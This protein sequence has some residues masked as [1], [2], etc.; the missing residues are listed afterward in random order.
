MQPESKYA[1]VVI[2]G[3]V[4]LALFFH[5]FVYAVPYGW[6]MAVWAILTTALLIGLRLGNK[7]A[8]NTWAYLFLGPVALALLAELL[9]ANEIVRFF[10]FCLSVI[11]FSFFA[12]WLYSPK[13]SIAVLH[14]FWPRTWILE[15]FF[16]LEGRS[17]L[18]KIGI[19]SGSR[20][21][22]T[23]V[24]AAIPFVL[25]FAI[26][27]LSADPLIGRIFSTTFS[28]D[29][30]TKL[31]R[32]LIVDAFVG[33]FLLR[34]IWMAYTRSAHDRHPQWFDIKP[35]ESHTLYI[36][37]LS[38]LNVLFLGF[39]A[40]QFVYFFG[41]QGIVESYGLTYASYAREGFFQL[42]TVSAIVFA[43]VYGVM[44]RT[45]AKSLAVR[46]L[47]LTLI[48]QS[49][50]VIASAIKR[51]TLYVDAYGLSVQ[52]YWAL[53]G[54]IVAALALFVLATWL[55]TRASFAS[56]SKVL[57]I[58]TLYIFSSLLLINFESVIV[59]WNA[60]RLPTESVAP[61]YLYPAELSTDAIPAYI[62]WLKRAGETSK[63]QPANEESLR[64][65]MAD[66]RKRTWSGMQALEAYDSL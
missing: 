2:A 34:W 45:R 53:A 12:Y 5:F 54:L 15:T 28:F 60:G 37:F 27:F 64:Q 19:G 32:Q 35:S 11:S 49:W 1:W 26:L 21:V 24:L 29:D 42:F 13:I 46:L 39:I 55:V 58:G 44:A 3:T 33:F 66:P 47:S 41:G 48:L 14:D 36:S 17:P 31:V 65:E 8:Q 52:R 59:N 23:G 25:V 62:A 18:N 7:S 51:L 40:F 4:I 57:A 22:L 16:P 6:P 43:I 61:D 10:G 56:L 20:Q 30:P 50:I 63:L 9:L 38:V